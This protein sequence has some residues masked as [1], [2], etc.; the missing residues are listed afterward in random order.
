MLVHK[1]RPTD[2]FTP[3][4][5]FFRPINLQST[6]KYTKIKTN[7]KYR[8]KRTGKNKVNPCQPPLFGRVTQ[9]SL[10]LRGD[11]NWLAYTKVLDLITTKTDENFSK[12]PA[13]HPRFR[14]RWL[15]GMRFFLHLWLVNLSPP[16][17]PPQQIRVFLEDPDVTWTMKCWLVDWFIGI[18]S[19][20][21]WFGKRYPLVN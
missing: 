10:I 12:V 8:K 3:M 2:L 13:S 14:C 20:K 6:L 5:I 19:N 4:H 17:V 15:E 1:K 16:N 9:K 11:P 18:F 21:W 7:K